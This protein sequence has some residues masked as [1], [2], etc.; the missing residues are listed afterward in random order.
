MEKTDECNER[1]E[2]ERAQARVQQQRPVV[3]NE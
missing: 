3:I 2:A 1:I